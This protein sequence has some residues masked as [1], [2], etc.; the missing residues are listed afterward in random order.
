MNID[1]GIYG[2]EGNNGDLYVGQ[3]DGIKK[4]WSCHNAHF[5]KN[6]HTYI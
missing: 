2:I 6:E 3:A 1:C 4:R 5:R